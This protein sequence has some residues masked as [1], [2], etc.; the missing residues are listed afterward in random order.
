LGSSIGLALIEQG[1]QRDG[2][3]VS[4]YC[5]GEIIRCRICNPTFYD[6]SNERLQA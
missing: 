1:S 6:P 4:V 5:D 2:E 3:T